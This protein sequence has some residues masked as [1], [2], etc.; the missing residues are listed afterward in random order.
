MA[1][2]AI[3]RWRLTKYFRRIT[4]MKATL[5]MEL[6]PFGTPNFAV[7]ERHEPGDDERSF[8][9]SLL[10][11]YTLERMCDE[12]RTAVFKKAGKQRPP[13]EGCRCSSHTS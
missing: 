2:W 9:L 13:Q 6:K 12:F 5:E 3:G 10:D 8:P 7:A 4:A 11:P 1:R